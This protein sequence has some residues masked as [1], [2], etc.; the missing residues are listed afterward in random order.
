[1][2]FPFEIWLH[3]SR[4]IPSYELQGLFCVNHALFNIAM[5]K[6]F[7][8]L[9]FR[10]RKDIIT[11]ITLLQKYKF[12]SQRVRRLEI[13][14][15]IISKIIYDKPISGW[16]IFHNVITRRITEQPSATTQAIAAM[17]NVISEMTDLT[18]YVHRCWDCNDLPDLATFSPVVKA[19]WAAFGHN[20]QVLILNVALEGYPYIFSPSLTF[21]HL[22]FLG[23]N[24]SQ[25][26]RT[27]D[28]SVIIN[29]LLVPF[30]NNHRISLQSFEVSSYDYLDLNVLFSG[31]HQLSNLKKV[32]IDYRFTSLEQTETAGLHHFLHI[33]SPSLQ[34]LD[35]HF[36]PANDIHIGNPLPCRWFQQDFLRVQLP[37][38][39]SLDLGMEYFAADLHR[40]AGYLKQ[41]QNSLTY[42]SLR[43]VAFTL[44]ELST[45]L[46]V[47]S[48]TE[49]LRK[50]DV[51][52]FHL[53]PELLDLLEGKVPS[54]YHLELGFD[55][56][57]SALELAYFPVILESFKQL[58]LFCEAL[59]T[60][61][62]LD[63][64][65]RHLHIHPLGRILGDMTKC[66][67]AI[68]EALPDL[69]TFMLEWSEFELKR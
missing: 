59:H 34:E 40:T 36:R 18:D 53:S 33:H 41:Y 64:K 47:F 30:I 21:P 7:K 23:I 37:N 62:Y 48:G 43:S 28:C 3:I 44:S 1:M 56:F 63:W 14:P 9:R 22:E 13:W 19:G 58:S 5:D 60:H 66:Q 31:L 51:N 25:A 16:K 38:L 61:K 10:R 32:K 39:Q 26:Y 27:T 2:E 49:C 4:F 6:R 11:N 65:L 55:R 35:L 17:I 68:S 46:D 29:D 69:E 42:L 52:V 12:H 45:L 24:I 57:S 8:L 50:L 15:Q 67:V 54:L 20:L